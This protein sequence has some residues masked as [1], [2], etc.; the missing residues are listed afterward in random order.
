MVTH[1]L[2]CR[3]DGTI[4]PSIESAVQF[5]A[6]VTVNDMVRIRVKGHCQCLGLVVAD[7]R[8]GVKLPVQKD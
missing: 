4:T 8:I 1:W 7:V 2:K 6:M 3:P 5:L